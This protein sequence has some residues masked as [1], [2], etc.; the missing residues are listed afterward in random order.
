MT[1]VCPSG[2]VSATTDYCDQCGTRI[3]AVAAPPPTE[4]PAVVDEVDTSPAARQQPCPSCGAARS[5]NDRYCEGCGYDF[6]A[7]AAEVGVPAPAA[8]DGSGADAPVSAAWDALASADEHQFERHAS[9]QIAFPSDYAERR[10]ALTQAEVRI[11]RSRGRPGE[12]IPELDLAATPEDPGISHMHAVLQRQEGG[13]YALRD[14]GSMNGTTVNDDPNP[15]GR[16]V[17]VPLVDG[18]RIHVGAWTTI[19]LRKR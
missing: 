19:T 17:A 15:I 8:A 16:E 3:G 18:D 4:A 2:H 14:L 5:G 10:F 1:A 12:Q 11:G 6:S 9:D 13:S 7:P